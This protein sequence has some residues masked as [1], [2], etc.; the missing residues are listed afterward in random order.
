MVLPILQAV[1]FSA[2]TCLWQFRDFF[3][4]VLD[5]TAKIVTKSD[6]VAQTHCPDPLQEWLSLPEMLY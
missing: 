5:N 2:P 4:S 6:H 3:L 1:L